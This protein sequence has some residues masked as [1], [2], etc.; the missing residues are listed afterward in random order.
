MLCKLMTD[1]GM[2]RFNYFKKKV[3]LITGGA[4][5]L[6]RALSIF[7]AKAGSELIILD[8]DTVKA[9]K[10]VTEIIESGGSCRFIKLDVTNY[11][12]YEKIIS[13]LYKSGREIDILINNAGMNLTGE[14]RDLKLDDW[15]KI[16]QLNLMGVV[17][18]ITLMYPLMV[19]QGRGQIVNIAS[20]AGLAAIPLVAPYVAT[21]FG[22]VGLSNVL[23]MEGKEFGIRVN[24]V[25]P[26]RLETD[27]L[28]CSEI[29]GVDRKN[30]LD[31]V[32]MKAFPPERAVKKIVAG[33]MKN[34][35]YIVFPSYVKWLWWTY[36][37]FPWILQPFYRYSIRQF[38]KLRAI[39]H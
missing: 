8:I 9:A 2:R 31:K 12:Q 23:R 28:E 30:F 3:V 22:V 16:I 32:P 5:G 27:L 19:K 15:D 34:K 36:R 38:R 24:T 11:V 21:K 14:V 13:G 17:N 18:G 26:G 10:T 37:F 33:M 20:M 25:C 29:I 39:S 1:P 6:G 4:N 35:P 7:L